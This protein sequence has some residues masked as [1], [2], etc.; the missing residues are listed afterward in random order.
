MRKPR[1]PEHHK[2]WHDPDMIRLYVRET[3]PPPPGSYGQVAASKRKWVAVG[4]KC[5][6]A[7]CTHVV[8]DSQET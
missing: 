3:I 2:S 7:D 4:W 8:F 6:K 1:C 5:H